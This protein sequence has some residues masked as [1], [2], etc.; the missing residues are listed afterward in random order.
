MKWPLTVKQLN[1]W[2][3]ENFQVLE[4]ASRAYIEFPYEV[5]LMGASVKQMYRVV[6]I[7]LALNG[8]EDLCCRQI[9]E[10]LVDSVSLT[11]L[12]DQ[13]ALLFLRTEFRKEDTGVYGRLAFFEAAQQER[14]RKTLCVKSEGARARNAIQPEV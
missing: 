6:F 2:V 8:D 9:A 12:Q 5:T 10:A 7:T 4:G 1:N 3:H 14:L 13:T 11:D